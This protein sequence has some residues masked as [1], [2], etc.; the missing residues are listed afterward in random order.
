MQNVLQP[1]NAINAP[2]S[3]EEFMNQMCQALLQTTNPDNIA[4]AQAENY[5]K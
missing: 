5:M 4:R 2:S 3:N 1:T